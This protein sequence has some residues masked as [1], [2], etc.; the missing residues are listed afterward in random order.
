MLQDTYWLLYWNEDWTNFI[1]FKYSLE[2]L[3]EILAEIFILV[4]I[5]IVGLGRLHSIFFSKVK[6]YSH[7]TYQL[8]GSEKVRIHSFQKIFF[9]NNDWRENSL[10]HNRRHRKSINSY[11]YT[12]GFILNWGLL[13]HVPSIII[14]FQGYDSLSIP[15]QVMLTEKMMS[16]LKKMIH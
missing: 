4:F 15:I 11:L 16:N 1:V 3:I 5:I 12:I 9:Q 10:I 2:I 6:S 13:K 14:I 7:Q 8:V